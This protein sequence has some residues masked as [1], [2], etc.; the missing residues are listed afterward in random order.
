M[1]LLGRKVKVGKYD[2]NEDKNGYDGF[3][4]MDDYI[5]VFFLDDEVS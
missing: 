2:C 4:V 1:E 5:L 3:M